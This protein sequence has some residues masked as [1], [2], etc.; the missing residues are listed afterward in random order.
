MEEEIEEVVDPEEEVIP[1]A[2]VDLPTSIAESTTDKML[3]FE[4][5]VYEIGYWLNANSYPDS[6]IPYYILDSDVEEQK[7][8]MDTIQRLRP[9]FTLEIVEGKIVSVTERD[10]TPEEIEQENTPPPKT[11]EQI[12]IE[13]LEAENADLWYDTMLKDARITEHD[14][15]IA[16]IWYAIMTGGASA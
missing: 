9:Y 10:K 8:L 1:V 5:G 14:S 15:D 6:A 12:R 2:P 13:Q 3:V 7:E 16:D 11:A 4:N